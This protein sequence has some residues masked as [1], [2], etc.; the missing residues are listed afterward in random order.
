MHEGSKPFYETPK[1]IPTA[2]PSSAAASQ[3]AE[4]SHR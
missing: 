3:A 2:H 4:P 1:I